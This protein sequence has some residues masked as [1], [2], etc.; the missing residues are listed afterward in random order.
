MRPIRVDITWKNS[1]THH[2]LVSN[3]VGL[4]PVGLVPVGDG[5]GRLVLRSAYG[6]APHP[7]GGLNFTRA[8]R[9]V[10]K[11]GEAR[12]PPSLSANPFFVQLFDFVEANVFQ[13]IKLRTNLCELAGNVGL[14]GPFACGYRFSRAQRR[15]PTY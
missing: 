1:D 4:V 7:F 3:P 13:L 14:G 15:C 2:F 6:T 12:Q 9:R 5:F 11:R 10:V 8:Q